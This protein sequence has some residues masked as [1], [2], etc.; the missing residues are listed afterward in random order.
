MGG[1]R[2]SARLGRL[3]EFGQ[4]L[5]G[6]VRTSGSAFG[7]TT[8]GQSLGIQPGVGIDYPLTRAWAARAELDVRLIATQPDTTNGGYQ[9][10]FV[11]ALVYANPAGTRIPAGWSGDERSFDRPS[12]QRTLC[13]RS[14]L[15]AMLT[16]LPV[17]DRSFSSLFRLPNDRRPQN[18]ACIPNRNRRP[19]RIDAGDRARCRRSAP[20]VSTTP[21]FSAL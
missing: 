1:L 7:S 3:T 6:V 19:C 13:S 11:A 10:R 16:R 18:F 5:A 2:A 12:R 15:R 20:C 9:Y 4:I 14:E 8:S 17:Q 21:V